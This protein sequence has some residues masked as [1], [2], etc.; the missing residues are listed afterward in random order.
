MKFFK[1]K[2]KDSTKPNKETSTE[3]SS[4]ELQSD[5]ID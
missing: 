2:S 5:I 3:G 4:K 1:F